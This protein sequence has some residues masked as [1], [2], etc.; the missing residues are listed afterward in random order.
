MRPGL[1]ATPL[2]LQGFK[3]GLLAPRGPIFSDV[4]PQGGALLPLLKVQLVDEVHG[5]G[6]AA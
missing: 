5:T 2:T 6:H 4:L 1:P 3:T